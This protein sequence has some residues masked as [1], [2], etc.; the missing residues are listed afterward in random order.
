MFVCLC[1]PCSKWLL[2]TPAEESA[3]TISAVARPIRFEEPHRAG[4][5]MAARPFWSSTRR[6]RAF[7]SASQFFIV[8]TGSQSE[9]FSATGSN[10]TSPSLP[11]GAR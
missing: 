5:R 3:D 4:P 11:P 2:L 6:P 7:L 8:P 10:M 1:V 9:Y